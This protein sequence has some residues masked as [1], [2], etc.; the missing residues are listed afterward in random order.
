ML[1]S[2]WRINGVLG[3]AGEQGWQG[4]GRDGGG[5]AWQGGWDLCPVG[6]GSGQN[7]EGSHR[8]LCVA[9]RRAVQMENL[10][11][12]IISLRTSCVPCPGRTLCSPPP[13]STGRPGQLPQDL[14]PKATRGGDPRG[15]DFGTTQSQEG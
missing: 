11:L 5:G 8:A 3:I 10:V 6:D 4:A 1:V 9:G 12:A 13:F 14:F 15:S 2:T 7:C